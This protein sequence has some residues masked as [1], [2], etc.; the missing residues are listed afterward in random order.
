M[1]SHMRDFLM[2]VF[3]YSRAEKSR[4]GS[5]IALRPFGRTTG[6]F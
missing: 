1:F 6:Q 5:P 3:S 2:L 4:R